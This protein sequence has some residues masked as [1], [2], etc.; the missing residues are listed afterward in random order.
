MV[1]GLEP[2]SGARQVAR[3]SFGVNLQDTSGFF[4]LPADQFDA[5]TLWH[6]LEH[7]H[8]L[9]EYIAQLKKLLRTGGRILVAVPNYTSGDAGHYQSFWAAYDVPRHLYHSLPR[10]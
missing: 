3:E 5:I 10:L 2:D 1:T 8:T 4:Q 6:V 7:V 9:H